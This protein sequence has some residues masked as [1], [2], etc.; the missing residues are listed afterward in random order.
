M[1]LSKTRTMKIGPLA[2]GGGSRLVLIGRVIEVTM[3]NPITGLGPAAY[4]PYANMKPLYYQ[5]AYWIHPLINSHNNYVDLF[6]HVGL[7]GLATGGRVQRR[8]PVVEFYGGAVHWLL[9]RFPAAPMAMTLGHTILGRT[10][11]ALDLAR[12]H[13]MVHVR[14]YQR[15]GPLF[16]PVYLLASLGLWLA[17]KDAYRDNPFEREAFEIAP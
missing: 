3:R 11:A 10:A 5:G 13:E 2:M 6:S 15:W 1:T 17:G 12:L 9:Q 4:R 7:L 14:Q 16:V 8:G